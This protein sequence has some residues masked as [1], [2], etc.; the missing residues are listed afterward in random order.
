VAFIKNSCGALQQPPM[1]S[2]KVCAQVCL[3]NPSS[4]RATTRALKKIGVSENLAVGVDSDG[5]GAGSAAATAT[6]VGLGFDVGTSGMA[7]E[8]MGSIYRSLK[9]LQNKSRERHLY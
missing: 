4:R 8:M 3:P 2:E 5:G 1:S 9:A 7:G 6:A